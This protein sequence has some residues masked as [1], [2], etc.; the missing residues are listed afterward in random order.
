MNPIPSNEPPAGGGTRPPV[1]S[2]PMTPLEKRMAE[3]LRWAAQAPEVRQHHG[4]LVVIRN[5]RI[6]AVGNDQ[7]ALLEQAA[8]QEGCPS[9][10]FVVEPVPPL[11]LCE[12]PH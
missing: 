5:Q 3:D 10:E 2:R 8:A 6:I 4:K 11:D 12:I 1:T 7:K 9:W